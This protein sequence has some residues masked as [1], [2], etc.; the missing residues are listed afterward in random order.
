MKKSRAL[1]SMVLVYA[2]FMLVS[3]FAAARASSQI[4]IYGMDVTSTGN[5]KIAIMFSV[6]GT[7]I[8]KR[9]GAE[10]I[11]IYESNGT[12]WK[13][14]DSYNANDSGMTASNVAKYGNTK[15]FYGN[16]GTKYK[17]EVTIFAE[18]KNGDS[19]FRSKTFYVTAQ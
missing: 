8:M 16:A 11:Y 10:S 13:L 19:D 4:D 12:G 18:D 1:V 6:T 9:L 17:I 3:P 2:L 14:A 7:N 15:Y 5:G